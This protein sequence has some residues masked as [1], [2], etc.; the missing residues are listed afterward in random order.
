M[1]H[2]VTLCFSAHVGNNLAV[3]ITHLPRSWESSAS[4]VARL[5]PSKL[6]GLIPGRDKSFLF[7]YPKLSIAALDP[8]EPPSEW[9]PRLLSTP[10]KVTGWCWGQGYE[11]VEL[12]LHSP[13]NAL[14]A[15]H[16]YIFL[17]QS[18]EEENEW[19]ADTKTH[20]QLLLLAA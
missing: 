15:G 5:W 6:Q 2:T 4:I 7:L 13:L 20:D 14:I 8:N 18:N 1:C 11:L 19:K 12:Y 9:L 10:G 16:L 17:D 3:I